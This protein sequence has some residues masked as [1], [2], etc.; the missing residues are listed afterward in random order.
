MNPQTAA[1]DPAERI[2]WISL[3][4]DPARYSAIEEACLRDSQS[5]FL[6]L[7]INRPA[8]F[9]GKNQN[10]WAQVSAKEAFRTGVSLNRRL[11]GGGTVY[12]DPGNL[13]FSIISN[14]EPK[15]AFCEHLKLLLHYFEMKRIAVEIRNRSDLFHHERKFSGNAEYFTGGRVL[16]HGTLLFETNLDQMS[17]LLTPNSQSYTDR[18]VDSNRSRTLNLRSLLPGLPDTRSLA[19]DIL[20]ILSDLY[21]TL[22][23]VEYLPREILEKSEEYLPR[24]RDPQWIFGGSPKYQL[25]RTCRS[26]DQNFSSKIAVVNGRISEIILN[27]GNGFQQAEMEILSTGLTGCL[28]APVS[29][30]ERLRDLRKDHPSIPDLSEVWLDLFF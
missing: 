24:F 19:E 9:V 21:P 22:R 18:A 20:G 2:A 25:E 6:I 26:A 29:F 11:S 13:N 10:L 16:H 30:E 4:D 7:W 5:S 14:G 1:P 27:T 28:H 23:E 15:I 3:D 17:R 8:L 12:H